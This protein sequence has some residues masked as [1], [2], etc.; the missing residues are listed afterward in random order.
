MDKRKLKR[1][2]TRV[3]Q[4]K[5]QL[6]FSSK[7]KCNINLSEQV[8]FNVNFYAFSKCLQRQR[9]IYIYY[10]YYLL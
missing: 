5:N 4:G 9:H 10:I 1:K 6:E 2:S 3:L 7:R 8:F